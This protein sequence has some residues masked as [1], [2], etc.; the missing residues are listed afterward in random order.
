MPP[1]ATRRPSAFE[2]FHQVGQGVLLQLLLVRPC[3][4]AEDQRE[5]FGVRLIDALEHRLEGD[6]DV[7]GD[8]GRTLVAVW[9]L[10][11]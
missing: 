1:E 5:G 3:D 7:V 6:A 8:A 2:G 11:R 4:V 9:D 10:D